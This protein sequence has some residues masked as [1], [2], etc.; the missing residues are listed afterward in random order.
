MFN[1]AI[2]YGFESYQDPTKRTVSK[3]LEELVQKYWETVVRR[4]EVLREDIKQR[5]F[6][7]EFERLPKETTIGLLT[8]GATRFL[9]LVLTQASMT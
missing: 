5:Y 9:W 3:A 8:N 4:G 7:T 1:H 2:G 6:P